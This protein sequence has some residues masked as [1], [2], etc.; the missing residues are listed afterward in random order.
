M[1]RSPA[2]HA[3][4]GSSRGCCSA[5]GCSSA[6]RKRSV[7]TLCPS[8]SHLALGY[9]D[10]RNYLGRRI[11]RSPRRQEAA[12]RGFSSSLTL[13]N[14][15]GGGPSVASP[16]ACRVRGS[17]RASAWTV[18]LRP[19]L[20]ASRSDQLV[21]R[22]P[23][24]AS[25]RVPARVRPSGVSVTSSPSLRNAPPQRGQTEGAQPAAAATEQEQMPAERICGAPHIRT[26]T[27]PLT[28]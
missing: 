28:R 12:D 8:P 4:M 3:S 2:L 25:S 5:G 24:F 20:P 7:R 13:H 21:D 11:M 15:V 18:P 23:C 9:T 19:V 26:W 1:R 22:S 6:W 17:D 27:K 10:M 16:R 14:W